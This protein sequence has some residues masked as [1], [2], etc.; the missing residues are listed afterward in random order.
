MK[1]FP[2]H[3]RKEVYSEVLSIYKEKK[4]RP[5][6]YG[7]WYSICELIVNHSNISKEYCKANNLEVGMISVPLAYPE[8]KREGNQLSYWWPEKKNAPRVEFLKDCIKKL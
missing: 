4:G 5:L 3:I 1:A 2:T 6:P 8:F 7:S